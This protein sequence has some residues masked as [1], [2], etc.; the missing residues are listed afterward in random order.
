MDTNLRPLLINGFMATGKSALA[1][2][3]AERTG[4]PCVDL[5]ARL[6]RRFGMS[7]ADY[8][9]G[10]GEAEFRAAER[11]ELFR[12]LDGWR[13]E[14]PTPPV[15]ALG[16]GAL[17]H[18]PTR[19]SALRQA[20]VVSLEASADTVLARASREGGRP[21][22]DGRP[23]SAIAEL[24]E[25][26]RPAYEQANALLRTDDTSLEELADAA[27][28]VWRQNAIVVATAGPSYLVEVGSGRVEGC[29][30][31]LVRKTSG[32]LLVSDATVHGLYGARVESVLRESGIA[33]ASV[34]L[35]PG[36]QAKNL[37]SIEQ[38]YPSRARA[39]D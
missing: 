1:A 15:C 21:L 24:M 12:L 20:V 32:L 33:A 18:R 22:L 10:H 39:L 26:R 35:T 7:I 28:R 19:L 27:I 34:V 6:V 2:L 31:N 29:L 4:R 25:Q 3:V 30:L 37:S 38:I 16:G 8:F 11:E 17:L 36:E 14:F 23:P 5:D 9:A 13:L